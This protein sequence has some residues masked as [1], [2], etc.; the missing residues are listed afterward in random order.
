MA[1]VTLSD[2]ADTGT[3]FPLIS[4]VKMQQM[5]LLQTNNPLVGNVIHASATDHE[6]C[7]V[8]KAI[9]FFMDKR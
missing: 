8:E 1:Q 2:M 7:T 3:L 6:V 9:K 4:E 5:E